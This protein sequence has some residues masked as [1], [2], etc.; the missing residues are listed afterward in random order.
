MKFTKYGI[1]LRRVLECDIELIRTWRNSKNIRNT[2]QFREFITPEMQAEWFKK[3]NTNSSLYYVIEYE[4][5]LIGLVNDKHIDWEKKTSE[6]GMFIWDTSYQNNY[7][8]LLVS[9]CCL[10]TSFF[11]LSWN[12]FYASILKN[13]Q[14]AI[15]YNK[16]MG[17]EL[18]ADKAE[19]ENAVYFLKRESYYHKINRIKNTVKILTTNLADPTYLLLEADDYKTGIA[20]KLEVILDNHPQNVPYIFVQN[21]KI[22]Y[23]PKD[24]LDV[25]SE[26]FLKLIAST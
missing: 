4:N 26:I 15:E 22:Y 17:F 2:M 16:S 8:P 5:K 11:F 24:K 12:G 14:R 9:L 6:A 19:T 25:N 3:I 20:Q 23:Y 10:D 1:I 13:N 18:I 7:T 21:K